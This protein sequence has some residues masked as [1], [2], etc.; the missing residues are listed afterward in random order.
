MGAVDKFFWNLNGIVYDWLMSEVHTKLYKDILR[1]LGNLDGVRIDDIGCGTGELIK[2]M[3]ET[4]IIRGID[5][6]QKA[7]A[8][9][10]KKCS[11]QNV[12]FYTMDFYSELPQDYKPDR[13]VACRSLYHPD[14]SL[15]LRILSEH[16]GDSGLAV[17]AHPKPNLKEYMKPQNG[18]SNK[19]N[20]IQIVKSSGRLFSRIFGYN[21]TLHSVQDFEKVGKQYFNSVKCSDAGDGTHN[22]VRLEK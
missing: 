22:L 11:S 12:K 17:I 6:S 16:L 1:G 2:R 8:K 14:L 20:L 9:A 3:P 13:V 7:I 5:Y 15:G 21:Y 10:Q 19:V 18:S 4:A